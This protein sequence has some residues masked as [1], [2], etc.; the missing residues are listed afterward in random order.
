[1]HT[2]P[3]R[4]T[5][6]RGATVAF[7]IVLIAGMTGVGGYYV[8]RV[9]SGVAP[10][11]VFNTKNTS[12]SKVDFSTF[13]QAWNDLSANYDG[14]P[15]SQK[16][17]DGAI[18]GLASSMGDPYTVYFPKTANEDFQTNLQ[19]SFGGIGAELDVQNGLLTVVDTL[20][21]TPSRQ[22]GL[23]TGDVITKINGVTTSNM[24]FNDAVDDIRGTNGT[25]VTLTIVRQGTADPFAVTM[26]R[27]TVTV[28]SVE[29]QSIGTNNAIAYIKVNQFGADTAGLFQSA[30]QDAVNSG[31]KGAV[32][33]LRDNPGGY[34]D[35]AVSMIGMVLPDTINSSQ[36]HL[37]ARIA[38]EERDKQGQETDT[39]AVQK[40]IA[41]NLPLVILVNGGSASASEIFSGAMIDYQRAT[42]LGTQTYGKGSVQNLL[43]LNNGGS[44]KV[45]IAK[46]FTPLGIGINGKGI[47]PTTVVTLP[48]D[49]ATSTTDA[50]ATQAVN[51]LLK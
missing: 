39:P 43:P 16:E 48:A 49:T 26:T 32:I 33:D 18:S 12:G 7:A 15:D 35:T 19:G 1:M 40:A 42:V 17:L 5:I 47:T 24:N 45:T 2:K 36:P 6:L 13:W 3:T 46:W 14:T 22:A 20:E 41:P 34:L 30:L 25:K 23:K 29:T 51:L 37:K 21:G 9:S 50:Q 4:H 28:K 44:I 8:G 27:A 38:V 10:S 11:N 31:K